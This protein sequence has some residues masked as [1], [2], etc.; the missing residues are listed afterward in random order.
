MRQV[1]VVIGVAVAVLLCGGTFAVAQP[2]GFVG[3]VAGPKVDVLFLPIRGTAANGR[4]PKNSKLL[5][6]HNLEFTGPQPSHPFV[7]GNFSSDAQW[8]IV[9]GFLQVVDGKNAALQIAWADEFQL[10]GIMEQAGF[11][12]WFFL[13]GWDEGRGFAIHNV[14]MKE[15]GSPWHVSEFRGAKAIE[16]RSQELDKYEWKGEQPFRLAIADA[17]VTLEVGRHRVLSEQVIEGYTPGRV[18]VG[19]YDTSYGPRPLR[20]K[21]LKIQAKKPAPAEK[22]E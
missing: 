4:L 5:P 6:I 12:G 11:G 19:V 18:I 22:P 3:A 2:E 16:G 21:S 7:L 10:E 15:S 20:I 8:G 13:V 1:F 14:T 9:D 17:K